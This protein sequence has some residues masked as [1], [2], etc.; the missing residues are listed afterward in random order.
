MN[1]I[2][3]SQVYTIIALGA[4]IILWLFIPSVALL[5]SM[6]GI[7]LYLIHPFFT[8]ELILMLSIVIIWI[9]IMLI[10]LRNIQKQRTT[11]TKSIVRSLFT[12]FLA[13]AT[14]I[15]AISGCIFYSEPFH[16]EQY[17]NCL[18]GFPG[19]SSPKPLARINGAGTLFC[20]AAWIIDG[21]G[22]LIK[23]YKKK[24]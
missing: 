24:T 14:V 18:V 17:N 19:I 2:A 1:Y 3:I 6:D 11:A 10:S 7:P 5:P 9:A 8:S 15:A 13:L 12:V 23:Y 16:F 21:V 22:K 4:S 20:E